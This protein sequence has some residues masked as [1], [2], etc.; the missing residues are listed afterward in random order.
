M[1]ERRALLVAPPDDTKPVYG[2]LDK[3]RSAEEAMRRH[4]N[5]SSGVFLDAEAQQRITLRCSCH[6]A[7]AETMGALRRSQAEALAHVTEVSL[8]A[9]VCFSG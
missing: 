7:Q 3:W 1:A 5:E 8:G 6:Q 2:G 4:T 9:P